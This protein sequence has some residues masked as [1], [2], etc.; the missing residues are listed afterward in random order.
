[1]WFSNPSYY[2]KLFTILVLA[3]IWLSNTLRFIL[4]TVP[5]QWGATKVNGMRVHAMIF[6]ELFDIGK[7]DSELQGGWWTSCSQ[8]Q[9][10]WGRGRRPRSA[11]AVLQVI[12]LKSPRIFF[13]NFVWLA[14]VLR[15][16]EMLQEKWD[17]VLVAHNGHKAMFILILIDN[18]KVQ[19]SIYFQ[20]DFKLLFSMARRFNVCVPSVLKNLCLAD[21]QSACQP[22]RWICLGE[23]TPLTKRI[24]LQT[25]WAIEQS[26]FNFNIQVHLF[27]RREF[28]NCRLQTVKDHLL[29]VLVAI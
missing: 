2:N 24:L 16:C 10:A 12:L 3:A 17:V 27:F 1:M 11:L 23:P 5:I 15:W 21:S 19:Y 26:A 28:G 6:Y 13:L 18:W 4:P 29:K 22:F 8:W 9:K 25:F 14:L 7:L 20:F